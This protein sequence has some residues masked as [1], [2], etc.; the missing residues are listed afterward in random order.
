MNN[1]KKFFING[2][3]LTIVG[4]AVRS[5]AISF[6]SFISKTI[7]AE[8]M[9]LYSLIGTVY[10]FAVT[11]ATS[12]IS[13][14]VTR[15]VSSAIGEGRE[16]EVKGILSSAV[17][18]ALIFSATATLT[19]FFAA[20]YF[21]VVTL[22]DSRAELPLRILSASLIPLALASV[23]SGYFVGVKRVGRNAAAQVICQ[24]FKIFTT[25]ILVVK[26]SGGGVLSGTVVL[27]V[28]T[29][30]TELSVFLVLFIQFIY[31]KRKK[32][33]KEKGQERHFHSVSSMALPL[34][35]S[36][37][38]R[39][40]LLMLEHTLIPKRLVDRGES[41]SMALSSYGIL[42]GMA[43]PML[44]YPMAPL[45]SFAGLLVPEFAEG[46][47]R[48]EYSRM[49]RV[50]NEALNTTLV[51]AIFAAVI[52]FMFSEELGYLVY[53]SYDAGYYI[54]VM[55]PVVPIMYLDHVA[56]S[57][58]KGIGE[59]VY[60]M[61][62]NISDSLLSVILVWVLIK[63]MGIGGYALVIVVMEGYNFILSAKRLYKRIRFKISIFKSIV[64]PAVS[65][66]LSALLSNRLFNISGETSSP[67]WL[68][69][70]ILFTAAVFIG[71]YTV[72]KGLAEVFSLK[73]KNANKSCQITDG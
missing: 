48:R 36:A 54:A 66:F 44:L 32:L 33:P 41:H 71:S 60:S 73:R 40:A 18:Y 11:F 22:S 37:Y 45:S 26:F 12:G 25:A 1:R 16:R 52:L 53:G 7:G 10:S 29:T 6:N 42:H 47:A 34:A 20:E 21:A 14:T 5:V 50:A 49:R 43:V 19:L 56:D 62:V 68:F 30:L 63:K 70:R 55:A 39:S 4:I 2:I 17:K 9:G 72:F 38:I 24:A 64:I 58:L 59:H 3:L 69:L 8:G 46:F 13:L 57:I 28:G 15:L 31:D 23:F 65:A 51:Y 67:V 35:V 61:W 27:C